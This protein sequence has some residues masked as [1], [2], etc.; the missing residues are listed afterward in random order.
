MGRTFQFECPHCRYQARVSGGAD[1]G[2]NC[3]IHTVFCRDC[4]E[5]F[6]V[7]VRIRK[8]VSAP[9]PAPAALKSPVSRRLPARSDLPPVALMEQPWPEFQVKRVRQ[10]VQQT[11][12]EE[13]KAACPVS[14]I[15]RVQLWHEPGRCPRCGN[16]MEKN[17]FAWRRWD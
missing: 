5:L 10:P 7:F 12:W 14:K 4:R 8:K 1:A 17:A 13:I 16:F 3:S 6:D 2:I 15:H 9:E 11:T